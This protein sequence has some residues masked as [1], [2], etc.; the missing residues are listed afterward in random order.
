MR[1]SV[2]TRTLY[3]L[4]SFA[5]AGINVIG[6]CPVCG[7]TFNPGYRNFGRGHE[8]N[9]NVGKMFTTVWEELRKDGVVCA[10]VN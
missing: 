1:T 9:C 2:D 8:A 4:L 3:D 10:L 5:Q 6:A 7:K